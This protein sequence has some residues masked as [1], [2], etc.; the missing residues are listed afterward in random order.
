MLYDFSESPAAVPDSLSVFHVEYVAR[1]GARYIS[2]AKKVDNLLSLLED[3][4][5]KGA[6]TQ[7][8]K[9]FIA[10]LQRV[11]KASDGKWG[12][13]SQEGIE[14]EQRLAQEMITIFPG[15]ADTKVDA[16]ST[17]V[18]RVVESMNTFT[19]TL[20]K[21]SSDVEIASSS[22]KQ[23]S[24]LLRFFDTWTPYVIWLRNGDAVYDGWGEPLRRFEEMHLPVA[25]AQRLISSKI[26][27]ADLQKISAQMYGVLQGLRA[28]GLGVPTT[29]WMSEEEY[30]ACWEC[31]NMNHYLKRSLSSLSSI[32][33]RGATPLLINII[34][35]ADNSAAM[36]AE[37]GANLRFG[38][39]ETLLPLAALMGLP[40][41][42]ALPL[43]YNVLAD[44][45]RDYEISPLGANICILFARTSTGRTYASVRLNSR[46]VVDWAPWTTLRADWLTRA[47]SI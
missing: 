21:N 32:P 4:Q 33:P 16:I 1:H 3:Y 15:I 38:H 12:M 27:K 10:L 18:P 29:Q 28:S 46:Q 47:G 26:D 2:S 9:E 45:W 44:E 20:A 6:L 23:Y 31:A 30:R 39:A 34:N 5:K 22:G 24:D 11:R 41:C 13:L 8:G 36:G 25:P 40:G 42:V 35:C 7:R 19:Y 17:Y 43:D 37:V 14:E